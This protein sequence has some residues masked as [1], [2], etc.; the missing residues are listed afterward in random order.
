VPAAP[1]RR[2]KRRQIELTEGGKLV[3]LGDGSITQ[4]DAAGETTGTWATGDPEW[5]RRA[6]RFGLQ[7][8]PIT[9]V[10]QAPRVSEPRPQV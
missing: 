5:A 8:Q 9:T 3:L 1:D 2:F 4:T 7:P 10:P 6:I